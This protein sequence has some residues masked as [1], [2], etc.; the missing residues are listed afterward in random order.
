VIELLAFVHV[1]IPERLREVVTSAARP[2]V[3]VQLSRSQI[4]LENLFVVLSLILL[5][6]IGFFL[7][8]SLHF[9]YLNFLLIT[10]I[11]IV[12]FHCLAIL[13]HLP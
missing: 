1:P 9:F 4:F 7:N 11:T 12:K 6:K 10:F 3:D 5:V 2:F 13:S 8:Q